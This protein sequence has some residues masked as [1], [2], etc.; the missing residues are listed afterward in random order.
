MEKQTHIGIKGKICKLVFWR[1]IQY[2]FLHT[3]LYF[4][5]KNNYYLNNDT[6]Q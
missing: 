2:C 6:Y 5:V 1:Q 3:P 4:E